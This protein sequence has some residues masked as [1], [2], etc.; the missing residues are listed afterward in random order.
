M[1]LGTVIVEVL[2]THLSFSGVA[3]HDFL[4]IYQTKDGD[5]YFLT[6]DKRLE[7]DFYFFG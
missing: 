2:I 7:F 4:N 5:S 6:A 3:V 1:C